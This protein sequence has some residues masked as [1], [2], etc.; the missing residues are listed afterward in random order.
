VPAG[1]IVPTGLLIVLAPSASDPLP[2]PA[3]DNGVLT[4][5]VAAAIDRKMDDGNPATGSITAY[6]VTGS[7]FS[8]TPGNYS[9]D[10]NIA[11]HDCGLI[12][13]IRP[14]Q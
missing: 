4:P 3:P 8:G 7:C 6:G 12:F 1:T 11:T 2:A 10:E 14:K 13:S 9:Y 5:H